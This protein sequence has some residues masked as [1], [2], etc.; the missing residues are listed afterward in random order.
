MHIRGIFSHRPTVAPALAFT[1]DALLV[2]ELSDVA[3]CSPTAVVTNTTGF[4]LGNLG[5]F[6]TC[7]GQLAA[8]CAMVFTED[9]N[10]ISHV[11]V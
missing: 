3:V 5:P 10:I 1:P 4:L 7:D 11:Q 6:F 2:H 8:Y 9:S